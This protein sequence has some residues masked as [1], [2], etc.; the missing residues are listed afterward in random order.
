MAN[1]FKFDLEC[2]ISYIYQCIY[3]G[4]TSSTSTHDP[5][6]HTPTSTSKITAASTTTKTSPISSLPSTTYFTP[7]TA[8]QTFTTIASTSTM[9]YIHIILHHIVA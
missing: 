6:C 5:W 8:Q 4:V 1:E 3:A 7:K 2:L 9:L